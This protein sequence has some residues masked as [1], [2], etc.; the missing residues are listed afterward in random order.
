MRGTRGNPHHSGQLGVS[1]RGTAEFVCPCGLFVAFV[2]CLPALACPVFGLIIFHLELRY[3]VVNKVRRIL[4][5]Y[6]SL[7]IAR[8]DA[9]LREFHMIIITRDYDLLW[10]EHVILG[11]PT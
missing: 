6:S 10:V 5:S 1:S 9:P 8:A 11:I 2:L 3:L 4:V 7:D